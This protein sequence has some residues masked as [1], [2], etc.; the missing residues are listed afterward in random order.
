M[1]SNQYLLRINILKGGRL[2]CEYDILQK[3]RVN[4]IQTLSKYIHKKTI[5]MLKKQIAP[6]KNGER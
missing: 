6:G 4:R 5:N 3:R 2:L 1:N